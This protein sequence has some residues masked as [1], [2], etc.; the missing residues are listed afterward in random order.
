MFPHYTYNPKAGFWKNVFYAVFRNIPF[1][2]MLA[3]FIF[4]VTFMTL[5]LWYD[6]FFMWEVQLILAIIL[7]CFA[8]FTHYEIYFNDK[9]SEVCPI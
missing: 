6:I 8:F 7:Y 3:N 4:G 2:F 1:N 9:Y 5:T